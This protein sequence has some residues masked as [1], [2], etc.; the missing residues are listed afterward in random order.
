[1]NFNPHEWIPD[2][3]QPLRE[4][5]RKI[6]ALTPKN[7]FEKVLQT[8]EHRALDIA[9]TYELWRNLG[10]AIAS[11]YGER[12]REYFHRASRY[13]YKYNASETDKQYTRC[14]RGRDGITIS[15]F[16]FLAKN[17]GISI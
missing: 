15:T 13:Y 3:K 11:E 17:A 8:I 4:V 14:L 10:F 12:G 6:S 1:M 16:F 2:V 9:P 5:V 7:Q